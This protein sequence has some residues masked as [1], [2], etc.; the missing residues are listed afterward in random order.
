MHH[1]M[2]HPICVYVYMCVYVRVRE[3]E[4]IT[5]CTYELHQVIRESKAE[6]DLQK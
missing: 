1:F 3:A 6:C 2:S 5:L 4:K